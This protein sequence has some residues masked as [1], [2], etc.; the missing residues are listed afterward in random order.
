M[1]WVSIEEILKQQKPATHNMIPTPTKNL[2]QN[3]SRFAG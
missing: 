2:L 1:G 3:E